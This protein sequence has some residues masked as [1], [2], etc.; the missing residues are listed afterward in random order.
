MFRRPPTED[1]G[2]PVVPDLVKRVIGLPGET[3]QGKGGVVYIDG[4]KL[5]EPWLPKV[6]STYTSNFGPLRIPK[7]DYF[8]MGDNRVDSCD[9]RDWGPL[10]S[11]YIVGKVILR[12]W[13]LSQI[14]T[15]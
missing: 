6:Q 15:F 5:A 2:G 12:I 7:G 8:M 3:I 9:S 10:P 14:T 1:C 11:S 13:P 4:K